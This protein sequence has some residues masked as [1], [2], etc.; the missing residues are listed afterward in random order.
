MKRRKDPIAKYPGNEWLTKKLKT[1][2]IEATVPFVHGVIRGAMANPVG[3]HPAIAFARI[4]CDLNPLS[5]DPRQLEKLILALLHLWNDTAVNY[6][7]GRRFPKALTTDPFTRKDEQAFNDEII[8]LAD[9]FLEGFCLARIPKRY[10]SEACETY[11]L[12]IVNEAK[13]CLNWYDNPEE[14]EKEYPEPGLR[15]EV[16]K[17]CLA[18]IEE[19]MVWLHLYA[20]HA[21]KDGHLFSGG[22]RRIWKGAKSDKVIKREGVRPGIWH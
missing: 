12:D 15:L 1:L 21:A 6:D 16:L 9:G 10:R 2:K 8:D 5:Y 11:F 14:F 19:T 22:V 4:N 7:M 13:L 3:I 18:M 20:Q 17:N